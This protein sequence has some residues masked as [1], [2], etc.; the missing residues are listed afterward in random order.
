LI[1]HVVHLGPL[2]GLAIA[3]REDL[4]ANALH[5]EDHTQDDGDE[6]D[7][8]DNDDDDHPGRDTYDERGRK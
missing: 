6:N 4:R 5:P 1:V 8:D 3:M 2:E 7:G